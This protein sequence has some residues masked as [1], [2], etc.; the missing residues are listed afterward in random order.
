MK[1]I[2]KNHKAFKNYE[3]MWRFDWASGTPILDWDRIEE[4]SDQIIKA[5]DELWEVKRLKG[6]AQTRKQRVNGRHYLTRIYLASDESLCFI[7]Y[8]R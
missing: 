4:L 7:L 2:D 1:I 3:K 6:Y 5:I 8:T